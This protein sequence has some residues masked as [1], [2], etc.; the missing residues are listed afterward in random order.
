LSNI[1]IAQFYLRN[2]VGDD[3]EAANALDTIETTI[4]SMQ[5]V[6]DEFLDTAALQQGGLQ[7]KLEVIQVEELLWEMVTQYSM[8]AQRKNIAMIVGASPGTVRADPSMAQ[9]IV[10]NLLSN[11]LKY[12]PLGSTV[13]LSAS[14]SADRVRICVADQ[15]PGIPEAERGQLF[16]PFAKLST[17]PTGGE[18]STGLGLWISSQ[19]V[20]V[21]RG[22]IGADFPTDGGSIFWVELPAST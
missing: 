14:V 7:L 18:S 21:Q 12:S 17:R 22:A 3:P 5:E 19:F 10:G 11:A 6:V 2:L 4:E 9:Q 16:Q 13:T 15:G 8:A 20:A 1:R